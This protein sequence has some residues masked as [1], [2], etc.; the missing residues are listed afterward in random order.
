M[1]FPGALPSRK[2]EHTSSGVSRMESQV[3]D[4]VRDKG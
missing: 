2:L 3:R 1:A 4:Q